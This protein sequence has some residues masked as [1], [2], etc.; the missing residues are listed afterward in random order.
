MP[1]LSFQ[2]FLTGI[3]AAIQ[4]AQ[5]AIDSYQLNV[6]KDYIKEKKSAAGD[7][8]EKNITVLKTISMPL[9]QPD[10]TCKVR[11]IP[12]VTLINHDSLHLEEVRIKVSL[13]ALWDEAENNMM[14]DLNMPY[15]KTE[16]NETG[17]PQQ[18]IE[19]IFKRGESPE[20]IARVIN[21]LSKTI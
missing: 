20:G 18:Q 4:H 1:G 3:S 12:L 10:G 21:E 8:V 7:G 17:K 13:S 14:V 5:S 6:Y 15:N 11:E 19:L 9:P 16:E 2:D